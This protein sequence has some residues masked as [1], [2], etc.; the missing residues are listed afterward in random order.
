MSGSGN[1]DLGDILPFL[2]AW[3]SQ[4]FGRE[5]LS[6]RA[7]WRECALCLGHGI[8]G[9]SLAASSKEYCGWRC[10]LNSVRRLP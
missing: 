10:A 7:P 9:E 5:S 2:L 1:G 3:L 4:I 8:S 6:V